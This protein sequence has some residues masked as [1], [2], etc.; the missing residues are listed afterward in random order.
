M[1]AGQPWAVASDGMTSQISTSTP[2]APTA[3]AGDPVP[4]RAAAGHREHA[5]HEQPDHEPERLPD[6]R[7]EERGT[8]SAT[9]MRSVGLRPAE[10]GD[11][12]RD[13]VDA[14]RAAR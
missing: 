12:V 3:G 4:E 14:D 6:R 7:D 5:V 11:D 9:P 2:S 13:E 10:R 1:R 8:S